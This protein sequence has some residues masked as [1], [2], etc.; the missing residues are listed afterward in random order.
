MTELI[1]TYL[2]NRFRVQP[3]HTNTHN[4]GHGGIVMKWLDEVGAMSAMRFAHET[5]VTAQMGSISFET[6]VPVG[7]IVL[8]ESFVYDTGQT[9]IQVQLDAYAEAARTGETAPLTTTQ[10]TY[11]AIDEETTDPIPVPELTVNS[12]S[13]QQLL[14]RVTD[15]P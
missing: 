5:V 11:V 6:P 2:E 8:I 13:G 14:D 10:A 12:E 3:N 7:D 9:S 1:D 15:E 4:T